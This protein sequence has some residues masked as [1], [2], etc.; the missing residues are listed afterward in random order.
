M[1]TGP[2]VSQERKRGGCLTITLGLMLVANPL[3]S[4]YYLL[5]GSTV[6]QAMPNIPG[7]AL[8]TLGLLSLANFAFVLG[9]WHWKK[10]GV[11][12]FAISSLLVFLINSAYLGVGTAVFGLLGIAVLVVLVRP[13][14]KQ[15]A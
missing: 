9:T 7:W 15:F 3:T 4:L 12:G 13:V 6:R 8:P 1:S 2:A 14:W 10:W 11:Y 5:A